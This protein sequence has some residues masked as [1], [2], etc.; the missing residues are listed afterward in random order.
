MIPDDKS[1][2]FSN[3]RINAAST[4]YEVIK[5]SP[6]KEFNLIDVMGLTSHAFRISIQK[7]VTVADPSFFDWGIIFTQGLLNLGFHSHYLGGPNYVTVPP[8]L[9][10]EGIRLIKRSLDNGLPA[11]VWD[12][13]IPEFGLIFG[14]DD[15]NQVFFAK[16]TRANST[17]SYSDLGGGKKEYYIFTLEGKP[18]K[19]NKATSL[20]GVLTM[21]LEHA[22][23]Q[24]YMHP[25]IHNGLSAYDVWMDAFEKKSIDTLGNAYNTSIIY[26]SR[27]FAVRFL[28][29]LIHQWNGST[30]LEKQINYLSMEAANH[31]LAVEQAFK[32]LSIMFPF[33]AGG[34]PIESRQA[35]RAIKILNWAK[36]AEY[37]GIKILEKMFRLLNN[38]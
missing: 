7:N 29:G 3:T 30:A 18:F 4:I 9:H 2:E 24:Q 12:L 11:I 1:S 26:D 10:V 38:S 16:D 36:N 5:H 35:K 15:H 27:K 32:W 21:V 14:Y 37:H 28:E 17:I 8:H 6:K 19:L 13:F 33:P 31:Y 20:H 25:L 22:F 23:S 34:N